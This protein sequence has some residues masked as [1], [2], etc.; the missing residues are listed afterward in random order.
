M[1]RTSHHT[2][3]HTR[4]RWTP[5]CPLVWMWATWDERLLTANLLSREFS[6]PLP[7][8]CWD[9]LQQIWCEYAQI[10]QPAT[11]TLTAPPVN[12]DT[13]I[14][15]WTG[16]SKL[17]FQ[18]LHLPTQLCEEYECDSTCS[19]RLTAPPPRPGGKTS[20]PQSHQARF[21]IL[22]GLSLSACQRSV[23]FQCGLMADGQSEDSIHIHS[24]DTWDVS[25]VELCLSACV[26]EPMK[27][28]QREE[29]QEQPVQCSR[30]RKWTQGWQVDGSRQEVCVWQ[31]YKSLD[32]NRKN[33]ASTASLS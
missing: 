12:F 21:Q 23:G 2:S 26:S 17:T 9:T 16:S 32:L 25:H 8:A 18:V 22:S 4:V 28:C 13:R 29:V 15:A 31:L 30:W 6:C 19:F 14:H 1:L 11:C 24:Q 33:H 10:W 5:D 7:A 27:W 20:G 3:K